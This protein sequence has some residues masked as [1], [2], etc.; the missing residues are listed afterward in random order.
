MVE[1]A[2]D[3]TIERHLKGHKDAITGLHFHP[4]N[5]QLVS[6]SMD[7]TLML[8]NFTDSIRGYKLKAH[9]DS[10]LD[11]SYAPSGEII[12]SASRD[13]SIRVW[14]PR[15]T[16]QS[17]DFKAHS[18]AVSSLHFCPNGERV[19]LLLLKQTIVI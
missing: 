13:R 4:T 19:F 3:P 10:V 9:K 11:V 14:I 5:N 7:K 8:W 12:A 2:C 1:T 18:G 6:S 17:V 15:I 16:G